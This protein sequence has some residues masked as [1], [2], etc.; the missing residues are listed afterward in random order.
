MKF[1]ADPNELA[2]AISNA[3]ANGETA[4]YDAIIVALDRLMSGGRDKKVLIAG[5][6]MARRQ[7]EHAHPGRSVESGR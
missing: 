6:A 7:Q 2:L 3:P 1:T 4:L 5:S